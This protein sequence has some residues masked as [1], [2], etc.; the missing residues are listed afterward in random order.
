[1]LN[2]DYDVR[3]YMSLLLW[4]TILIRVIQN[5]Y[6]NHGAYA[7]AMYIYATNN[8]RIFIE[9]IQKVFVHWIDAHNG[10]I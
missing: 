6:H 7:D 10:N 3:A 2:T 5:T 4:W 8:G 1:M 9:N